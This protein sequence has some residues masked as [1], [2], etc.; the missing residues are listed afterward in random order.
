MKKNR[1]VFMGAAVMY[2]LC[3]V[4]FG[5]VL[6]DNADAAAGELKSAEGSQQTISKALD[7]TIEEAVKKG[8]DNSIVL[9]QVQNQI[10]LSALSDERAQYNS[11]QLKKGN[12]AIED[13]KD[14][15]SSAQNLL[16]QGKAPSDVTF[17]IPGTT[18]TVTIP[19]NEKI[20]SYLT[21]LGEQYH[22][23]MSAEAL[24]QS[25]KTIKDGIQAQIDTNKNALDNG[26]VTLDMAL[27]QAGMTL[28]D[29]LNVDNTF[30]FSIDAS[31]DLMTTMA[32]V[33]YNVTKSSYAIYRNQLAL[34]LQKCCYD[35]LK[36]QK[37]LEVKGK[38]MERG[39]KQYQFAK[40]SYEQG[41]KPKDDLLL[42]NTYYKGTQIEYQKAI[43][44]L[45]N[46]WIELKKN[47]NV[48][49]DTQI[50]LKDTL[51]D[52]VEEQKLEEGILSGMQNRLEIKKSA[53]EVVVYSMNLKAV[54][55]IYPSN[56]FQYREA[57]LVSQKALINFEKAK[58]D[59]ESSI[60]QSYETLKSTGN[61]LNTSKE[62]VQQAKESVEI[63]EYKYQEGFGLENSLLKKLDIE[64]SAG[65]IIEVLAAEENLAQV[66]QKA[67]EILYGYNLAKMKY[68]NDIGK[69][70]Y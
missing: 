52:Q 37:I 15:V 10:D 36:A 13:G 19:K 7:L 44:E 49:L 43:G 11:K 45:N 20:D 62:M 16:N 61:M 41:M 64:A 51:S 23:P 39:A 68:F 27:E 60:Y 63:A 53:G 14:R 17:T 58:S 65:T 9:K 22:L 50:Q 25:V 26:E 18:L 40:D 55:E 24:E 21:A 33:Q 32:G 6:A 1:K 66:E 31:R 70:I 28:A 69:L 4:P 67:V 59:V 3:T 30:A 12:D 42:A 47:I 2:F 57:E 34:Q 8:I 46:A 48:P 35:V 5:L 56:T 29:K 54:K 38:A